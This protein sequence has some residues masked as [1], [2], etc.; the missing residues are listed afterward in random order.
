MER[1]RDDLDRHEERLD[2]H[3]RRLT[4]VEEDAERS[5]AR[6]HR[7]EGDRRSMQALVKTTH[8]LATQTGV[9]AVKVSAAFDQAEALVEAA[10]ERAVEKAY[11]RRSE[12]RWRLVT[13]LATTLAAIAGI[14]SLIAYVITH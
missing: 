9:L 12:N 4:R 6:L 7:L 2:D 8:Q 10:A 1:L 3:L 5:R 14:G 13:R 11:G